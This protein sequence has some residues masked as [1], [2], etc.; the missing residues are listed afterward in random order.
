MRRDFG[1]SFQTSPSKNIRTVA[2][3]RHRVRGA[4]STSQLRASDPKLYAA[5]SPE[6]MK[7]S[8]IVETTSLKNRVTDLRQTVFQTWKDSF[9][10][11][12]I[13]YVSRNS[14]GFWGHSKQREKVSRPTAEQMNGAVPDHHENN[15][16]LFRIRCRLLTRHLSN[17][18]IRSV[19]FFGREIK[20][21]L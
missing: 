13:P 11:A 14:P 6:L 12:S 15:D 5:R 19:N 3:S 7:R 17:R 18:S 2:D 8:A 20:A 9:I 1:P 16:D 10:I 21:R 4:T